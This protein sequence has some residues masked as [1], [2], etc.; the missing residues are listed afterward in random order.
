MDAVKRFFKYIAVDTKS[1]EDN[2][3]C[4]STKG[5]LEL[6][7]MLVQELH[8]LGVAD[9]EQDAHGYVYGTIPAN[10]DKKAPVIGFIAHMDTAPDL[11]GKCVNPQIVHYKGGDI[12]LNETYS[13][14]VNEFPFLN[15]LIGE[16]IITTDGTTRRC[17]TVRLKS[18]LP[19]TRKSAEVQTSSM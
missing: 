16:D 5:Q 14:T 12:K 2:P 6:G 1:N 13:L 18:A 10:T 8:E 7:K 15:K 9:A 3:E 4:P 11:D 19:P 17:S